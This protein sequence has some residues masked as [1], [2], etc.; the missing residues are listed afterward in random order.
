M[1]FKGKLLRALLAGVEHDRG[2]TR[3]VKL[4]NLLLLLLLDIMLLSLAKYYSEHS[5]KRPSEF[6]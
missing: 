4:Q 5:A 1:G 2:L 6:P 3:V